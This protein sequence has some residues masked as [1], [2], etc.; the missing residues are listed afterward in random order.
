MTETAAT[1]KSSLKSGPPPAFNPE[2]PELVQ[3]YRLFVQKGWISLEFHADGMK[4]SCECFPGPALFKEGEVRPTERKAYPA[5]VLKDKIIEMK[6]WT[7]REK[8]IKAKKDKELA[9]P[10]RSLTESDFD[11]KTSDEAFLKRVAAVAAAIGDTR[12][13]GRIG[14]LQLMVEGVNTFEEW[15]R[16]APNKSKALLLM[17]GKRVNQLTPTDGSRLGRL[18]VQCPFRGTVPS[19][20]EEAEEDEK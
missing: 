1:A 10:I 5:S 19:P 18:V 13:R 17:D 12:A 8:G 14:S 15:W 20:S 3:P 11:V 9:L 6:L 4:F 2:R 7:P 16:V